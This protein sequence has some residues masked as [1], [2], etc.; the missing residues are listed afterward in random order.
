MQG[1]MDGR[2]PE[3]K[4]LKGVELSKSGAE[5]EGASADS[6]NAEE[7][8]LLSRS[9]ESP[10]RSNPTAGLR[11]LSLLRKYTCVV[12]LIVDLAGAVL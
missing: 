4:N 10:S 9:H 7:Q 5:S 3:S 6:A 8:P 2:A 1:G 12:F 11:G